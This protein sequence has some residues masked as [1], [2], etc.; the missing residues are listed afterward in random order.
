MKMNNSAASISALVLVL[1]GLV[2][3]VCVFAFASG[4]REV[5]WLDREAAATGVMAICLVGSV[6][7]W[8]AVKTSAGRVAAVLGTLLMV[9]YAFQ[10]MR[11]DSPSSSLSSLVVRTAPMTV[12]SFGQTRADVQDINNDTR[13]T[14]VTAE[15]ASV[16][17][18]K[19]GEA[20][21]PG[22]QA[23]FLAKRTSGGMIGTFNGYCSLLYAVHEVAI[24][25][26]SKEV[27]QTSLTSP[28]PD[29]YKPTWREIFDSVARQTKSSWKHDPKRD[30]WVFAKP[31]SSGSA[32]PGSSV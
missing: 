22:E 1:L 6:L 18:A 26:A 11:S 4:I 23:S 9:F 32:C 15:R 10:L 31:A 16:V 30:Y 17:S 5:D 12:H 8:I 29:F 14:D 2:A 13:A 27:N 28:F 24:H 19:E 3:T 7:G 20:L 21:T 25:T